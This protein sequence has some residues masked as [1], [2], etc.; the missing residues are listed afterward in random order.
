MILFSVSIVELEPSGVTTVEATEASASVKFTR[1]GL[2]SRTYHKYLPRSKGE[3]FTKLM[4]GMLCAPASIF[5]A[6]PLER[7]AHI[8]NVT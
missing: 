8:L 3:C 2:V 5:L 6:T 7:H 1:C 4:L